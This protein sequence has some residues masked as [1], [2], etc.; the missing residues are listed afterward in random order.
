M[1]RLQPYCNVVSTERRYAEVA[2][3]M[4]GFGLGE[5]ALAF[6][7]V[8]MIGYSAALA[9][10]ATSAERQH[11][12]VLAWGNAGLI[13]AILASLHRLVGAARTAQ[14]EAQLGYVAATRAWT[15]TSRPTTPGDV[16]RWFE[17]ADA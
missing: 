9:S 14:T 10:R 7:P 15:E 12:S 6:L 3:V 11:N 13:R 17:A 8:A 4:D 1:P 2:V 16:D 5:L